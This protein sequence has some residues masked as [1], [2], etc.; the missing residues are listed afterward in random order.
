[1]RLFAALPGSPHPRINRRAEPRTQCPKRAD[2]LAKDSVWG[3]QAAAVEAPGTLTRCFFDDLPGA[4]PS[5]Q[6]L[7]CHALLNAGSRALRTGDTE[8]TPGKARVFFLHRRNDLLGL[9]VVRDGSSLHAIEV[10]CQL[11]DFRGT[12]A[13][14]GLL[15]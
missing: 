9:I 8:E 5:R 3:L 15:P 4:V 12:V 2:R 1:S 6:P 10:A 11:G 13:H 14:G 7:E